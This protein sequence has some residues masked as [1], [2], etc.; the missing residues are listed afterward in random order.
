MFLLFKKKS[1]NRSCS[2]KTSIHQLSNAIKIKSVPKILFEK[3][4]KEKNR[5]FFTKHNIITITHDVKKRN[6]V[7][8]TD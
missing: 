3:S 6:R 8:D 7:R 2:R 4:F 5:I 1:L